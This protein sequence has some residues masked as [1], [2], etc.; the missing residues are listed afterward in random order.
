MTRAERPVPLRTITEFAAEQAECLKRL[1]GLKTDAELANLSVIK[2]QEEVGEVAEAYL[3]LQSLQRQDKL[4]QPK[5][6]LKAS[7]GRE[8]ADVTV[9][10]A[11]LADASGLSF[12]TILLERLD[13]LRNR[14]EK[15]L[16]ETPP[17]NGE[18]SYKPDLPL[19]TE[20]EDEAQLQ[21]FSE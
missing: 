6:E 8:I 5:D 9:V 11:L 12:D 19:P 14:R 2:L 4:Q 1:F 18:R 13:N 20:R 15:L 17:P 3:A 10:M 16:A 21:F 7:L